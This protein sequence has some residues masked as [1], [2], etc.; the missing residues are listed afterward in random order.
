MVASPPD[1]DDM[2]PVTIAT[3]EDEE[4]RAR[5]IA[6]LEELERPSR[7]LG[8]LPPRKRATGSS[9]E[10]REPKEPSQSAR[11]IGRIATGVGA[12]LLAFVIFELAL[13]SVSEIRAQRDLL[14]EFH[15]A[16]VTGQAATPDGLPIQG[17]PVAF[18]SVPSIGLEKVVV[19]G[20]TPELLKEGPGHFRNT[21]LPGQFG[22]VVIAARR[23]TYGKPF[24]HLDAVRIGDEIDVTTAEGTF[25]YVVT[26]T[27]TVTAGQTD[28]MGSSADSRLTLVTSDPPIIASGRVGLIA[29]LQGDPLAAPILVHPVHL[30][31]VESGLSGDFSG[32]GMATLFS[33]LLG[34]TIWAAWR[35][36][37]S[38]SP[39]ATYLITTPIVLGLMFALFE[40]LDRLLPGTI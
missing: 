39:V 32:L 26:T 19:E 25:I 1:D 28:V 29:T 3:D 4:E 23:T 9:R 7:W 24:G 40:N 8:I 14:D 10:A 21:P 36:Y 37:H 15:L 22:N 5:V 35:L 38:W 33:F 20:T 31:P 17:T 6:D 13:S 18:L 2:N 12:V 27:G 34:F 30:S 11:T 16:L